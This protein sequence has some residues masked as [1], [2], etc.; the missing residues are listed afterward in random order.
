M[1][2]WLQKFFKTPRLGTDKTDKTPKANLDNR[3]SSVLSVHTP[4]VLEKITS[5]S[6]LWFGLAGCLDRVRQAGSASFHPLT[7]KSEPPQRLYKQVFH[8]RWGDSVLRSV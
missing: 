5:V 1:G 7:R 3:V 2:R 8:V 4:P 6:F